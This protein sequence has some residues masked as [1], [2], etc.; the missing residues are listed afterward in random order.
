ML[1]EGRRTLITGASSGIGKATAERFGAE[2]ALVCVNY[3]SDKEKPDAQAVCAGLDPSGARAFAFQAD[4]GDEQQVTAM[5]AAVVDRFGGI[6]VLVN[7]AGIEKQVATLE[8]PLEMWN[9]VLRTNLTGAFLCLRE[10][11]KHMVAQKRGVIVNMSSV[12]EF[13]PWPGFAHY[14]ASKGGMKLLTQTVAREL[15]AQGVRCLNVAPGAIATPINDF[16]LD[17]AEAK[18]QVEEEIPLGRFGQPEEIAGAVAWA[19]SDQAA[20]VTGTTLVVDGGMSTY[21][22]FI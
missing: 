3:F 21:P 17:D 8:M 18:H 13:I 16:V 11:G 12:H 10:A 19:A 5:I 2:G 7:N 20:Y 6:D 4:V 1:L 9:A 15:A 22:R 14:C